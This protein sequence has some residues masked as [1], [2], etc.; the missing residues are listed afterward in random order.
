MAERPDEPRDPNRTLED[1]PAPPPPGTIAAT[2]GP[3]P[4]LPPTVAATLPLDEASGF[5]AGDPRGIDPGATIDSVAPGASGPDPD[6][7]RLAGA[8]DPGATMDSGAGGSSWGTDD[9]FSM[10]DPSDPG[11]TIGTHADRPPLMPTLAIGPDAPRKAAERPSVPGYEILGELG[12]GGMGVVY[13]ARQRGLNRLV[14]LKMVLAGSHAG[15]EALARFQIEA[16]A[17][18]SLQHPN[19]VQIYEV[20]EHLGLPFFSL[21]YVDGGTLAHLAAG[22]PLPPAKSAQVVEM[23]ARAMAVAHQRGV[24]HR[25]LKPANVLLTADGTPKITDFG[26]AKRLEGD[27]SQTRSGTLMGTPSYMAPEQARGETREIGPAADQYALGA[28]LYELLTGRPPFQGATP[29]DTLEQVRTQEPVPPTRLQPKVPRDLETVCLKCLQKERHQRYPDTQALADDLGRFTS[30]VPILARPVGLPERAWRW[31]RRNPRLA[32]LYA[33]VLV[34]L[35]AVGIIS[36]VMAARTVREQRAVGES[37]QLARQ[38]LAQATTAVADGDYRRARDLLAHADPLLERSS[39]LAAERADRDRLRAQVATYAKFRGLMD[40]SRYQGLVGS[41]DRPEVARGRRREMLDLYDQIEGRRGEA[42]FGLPPLGPGPLRL[43]RE[44]AFES[45]LAAALVEWDSS[46][47][48]DDPSAQKEAARRGIEWLNRAEALLPTTRALYARRQDLW[49][50][51]GNKEAAEADR[52]RAEAI[53]PRSTVDHFWRGYADRLRGNLADKRGDR[54]EAKDHYRKAVAEFADVLRARPEHF[55]AYF[56]WAACHYRIGEPYDALVGFSAC[57]HIDPEKPWPYHNRA[58]IHLDLKQFDRAIEDETAAL[59]RDGRYAEAYY[60]RGLART[61]AGDKFGAIEDFAATTRLDPKYEAAYFHRA[62]LLRGLRRLGEALKGYDRAIALDPDRAE[63]R[64]GRAAILANRG[65]LD[66]ARDDLTAA[67][68]LKPGAAEPYRNRGIVN[69]KLKDFDAALADSRQYARLKPQDPEIHYRIGIIH[70]GLRQFDEA[71]RSLETALRL[72]PDYANAFLAR[73]QMEHIEGKFPEALADLDHV[74]TEL[75]PGKAGVLNDRGDLYRAMG[76]LDEAEADYMRSIESEPKQVDPYIGLA[77]VYARRGEPGRAADCD[78]RMVAAD[79]VSARARLRRAE[80]RRARGDFDGA[81]AD[82]DEAARLDPRSPLPALV[83]A[84]VEAARGR[85]GPAV[86]SAEQALK[87]APAGDGHALY[88]ASCVW[89]LASR[90]AAEHADRAV[91]LLVEALTKGFHDLNYQE[92]NRAADDPALAGIVAD[93]RV[94][95]LLPPEARP[96]PRDRPMPAVDRPGVGGIDRDQARGSIRVPLLTCNAS[97]C[98]RIVSR[99]ASGGL[100]G[101]SKS[102]GCPELVKIA[103]TAAADEP[104][105][106]EPFRPPFPELIGPIAAMMPALLPLSVREVPR[107]ESPISPPEASAPPAAMPPLIVTLPR[108]P[109]CDAFNPGTACPLTA[110]RPERPPLTV[111]SSNTLPSTTTGPLTPPLAVMPPVR[112]RRP[113]TRTALPE[114][115]RRMAPR[116]PWTAMS[117]LIPPLKA[118]WPTKSPRAMICPLIP[119]LAVTSS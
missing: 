46:L 39:A 109:S 2:V 21:E 27:S 93:P 112:T 47:L 78:D 23:L 18:A 42:R 16:E 90:A 49:N 82:C 56:E 40:D 62:E 77:L 92:Y 45:F 64:F 81:A 51:L 69:L 26:L 17:V 83:R 53:E 50:R 89:A 7:F 30:G 97:R 68:R 96:D 29:L 94:R 84:G 25:D 71:R 43:F 37:R 118:A 8:M 38:R 19:I 79:P 106:T 60:G 34:L 75:Q 102:S 58:T 87:D 74:L 13:K 52:K 70:M 28:I 5:V 99:P 104:L 107:A 32:S 66:Q 105:K 85:P 20:G 44:D 101:M 6:G 3:T 9:G 41:R 63:A 100:P 67:I 55:W 15:P 76:R 95:E 115:S 91:A 86:A 12:R 114:A 110:N 73:A 116:S 119:P 4:G 14:A 98:A 1:S 48:G 24:V 33:S 54:E 108:M 36:T 61:A 72:K 22:K 80:A 88:A 10:D 117:P 113:A 59:A 65:R 11:A 31:C 111:T 35:A 103:S 57:I